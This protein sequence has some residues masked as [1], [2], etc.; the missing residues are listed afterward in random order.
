MLPVSDIHHN[1][2]GSAQNTGGGR[3]VSTRSRR[4][5]GWREHHH[6]FA[7]I[8][9]VICASFAGWQSGWIV[10]V[11]SI[12][13]VSMY[14]SLVAGSVMPIYLVVPSGRVDRTPMVGVVPPIEI[15]RNKVS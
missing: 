8:Q 7:T 9:F 2:V 6:R 14:V 11:V 5:G 13:A 10:V 3:R 1:E 4:V 12:L 15:P